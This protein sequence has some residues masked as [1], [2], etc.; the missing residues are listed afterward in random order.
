VFSAQK[1]MLPKEKNLSSFSLQ[2]FN[3]FVDNRKKIK[4]IH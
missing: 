3:D 2:N 4:E 1:A